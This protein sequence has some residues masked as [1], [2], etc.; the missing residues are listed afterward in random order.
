MDRLCNSSN[1]NL[2][3][4]RLIAHRGL[5]N[6]M[7]E[8]TLP[9][10]A[11]AIALGAHEIEFDLRVSKDGEL[12]VCHDH[13]VDRTSNGS[14]EIAALLWHEVKKLDAGTWKSEIW[15]NVRFSKFEDIFKHFA[16]RS[17]FNIHVKSESDNGQAF[18]KQHMEQ[19]IS[20]I[21][22][23]NCEDWC[24]IAGDSDILQLAIAVDEKIE[25]CC[26][27]GCLDYT[28]VDRAIEY[29]C[30]KLQFLKPYYNAE[31]IQKAHQH[32]ITCNMFWADDP[33]EAA[34]FLEE[35]IDSVLTNRLNLLVDLF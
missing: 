35:G 3:F 23:Y 11:A 31:M 7:P 28:I 33:E 12:V 14:G 18:E 29:Q 9:A 17:I 20:L 4:P 16:H 27:A 2:R 1:R 13:T 8:N 25:R 26:L 10:F 24:Y 32:G 21:K 6:A 19:L 22:Q 5:S 34:I 30:G 15:K